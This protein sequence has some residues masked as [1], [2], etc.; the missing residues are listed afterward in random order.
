M[1]VTVITGTGVRGC[2]YHIKEFFLK[3]LGEGHEITGFVLPGDAPP[4]CLGCKACFFKGESFCPHHDKVSPVW[5]ALL[6][7]DLIVFAY[8]VYVLRAPA[9]VKALL[10]HLAVHWMVHRPDP[11]LFAKRAVILTNSVGAPNGAA[12]NDVATSLTWL[13][14]PS[15]HKLGFGLMEGVIWEELSV[16]R[17]QMIEAKTRKFAEKFRENR[18]GRIGVKHR[19]LFAICRALHQGTAKRENPLSLDNAYWLKMGWIKKQGV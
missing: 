3:G 9:Q 1:R 4:Y 12:Q 14:I 18:P 6:S 8:P 5:N 11:G 7:A 16:R 17:R 10:D 19:V 13:G 15:V 2:T